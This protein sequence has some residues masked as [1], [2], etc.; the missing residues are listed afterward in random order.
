MERWRPAGWP[1]GV[2]AADPAMSKILL[3]TKQR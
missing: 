1:G 2:L 3:V